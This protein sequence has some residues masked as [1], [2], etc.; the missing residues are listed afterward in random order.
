MMNLKFGFS[1][2]H[3]GAI[4]LG[5][6][7]G[8][9][10]AARQVPLH[11]VPGTGAYG[12][13]VFGLH[14]YTWDVIVFGIAIALCASVLMFNRQFD[15]RHLRRLSFV[16]MLAIVLMLALTG[17]NAVATLLECGFQVCPD[18]PRDFQL[19]PPTFS[20]QPGQPS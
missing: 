17:A 8:M 13:P 9:I 19:L 20:I 6:C 5:A 11:I 4:L 18:P 3:Y 12:S 1:P 14:Y 2:R 15:Q 7:T 16:P 10:F